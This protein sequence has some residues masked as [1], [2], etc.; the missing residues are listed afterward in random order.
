MSVSPTTI[1]Q[2]LQ[3]ALQ[4]QVARNFPMAEALYRQV[5]ARQARNADALHYLGLILHS[6][7]DDASKQEGLKLVEK[8]LKIMPGNQNFINN[9]STLYIEA[10]DWNTA[11]KICT[12]VIAAR[13]TFAGG[14]HNLGCVY[15]GLEQYAQ[16][17]TCFLTALKFAPQNANIHANLGVVYA[18]QG[19]LVAAGA[20]FAEA[21][22]NFS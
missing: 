3:R 2:I 21:F 15:R 11:L 14:H 13:P 22:D 19:R 6:K 10:A 8:S 7:K 16:A 17:E 20:K 5:L 9:L 4:N 1:P 18:L 12:Q